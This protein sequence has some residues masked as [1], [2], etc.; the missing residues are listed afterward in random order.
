MAKYH[1]QNKA[2]LNKLF[3]T[4]KPDKLGLSDDINSTGSYDICFIVWACNF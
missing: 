2:A 4:H 3:N 1:L